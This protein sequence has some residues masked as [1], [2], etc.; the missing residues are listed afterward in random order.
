M[1]NDPTAQFFHRLR[2]RVYEPL[3][4]EV[5]AVVRFDLLHDGQT[6][7]WYLIINNGEITVST[8]DVE[9]DCIIAA[10]RTLFNGIV[11]GRV[12]PMAALLRGELT[13]LGEPDLLVLCRRIFPGPPR[14]EEAA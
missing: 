1:T 5:V 3:V 10:D 9:A 7:R 2:S 12:N 11:S 13:A 6:E 4:R 8:A 14:S